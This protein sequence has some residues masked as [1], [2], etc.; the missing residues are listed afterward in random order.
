MSTKSVSGLTF[1]AS[2]GGFVLGVL[3]ILMFQ[4]NN[5]SPEPPSYHAQL[6]AI[7]EKLS[8]LE[9]VLSAKVSSVDVM[10]S[11]D[12]AVSVD[13]EVDDTT[14]EKLSSSLSSKLTAEQDLKDDQKKSRLEQERITKETDSTY[15]DEQLREY[16]FSAIQEDSPVRMMNIREVMQSDQMHAM[17]ADGRENVVKELVRMA[18]AGELDI[19]TFFSN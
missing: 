1:V 7:E 18:N 6:N 2:L 11:N 13:S 8:K 9:N 4:D 19:N 12:N 10:Y 17:T 5:I 14:L 3:A 15:Q 16:V